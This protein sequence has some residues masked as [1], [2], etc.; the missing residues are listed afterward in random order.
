MACEIQKETHMKKQLLIFLLMLGALMPGVT[1]TMSLSDL[2]TNNFDLILADKNSRPI[3]YNLLIKLNEFQKKGTNSLFKEDKNYKDYEKC[4]QEVCNEFYTVNKKIDK[5]T[6]R[7][8]LIEN[9]KKNL[10]NPIKR[11]SILKKEFSKSL[12]N[13][14]LAS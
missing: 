9:I 12:R 11:L 6:K 10:K 14:M 1:K 13:N 3:H 4:Y 7:P 2:I 8:K 5:D